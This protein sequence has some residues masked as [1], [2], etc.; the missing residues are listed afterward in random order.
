VENLRLRLEEL[1]SG[2]SVAESKDISHLLSRISEEKK[3]ILQDVFESVDV[4]CTTCVGSQRELLEGVH[5]PVVIVDGTKTAQHNTH[6]H[7]YIYMRSSSRDLLSHLVLI[8]RIDTSN[9][10]CGVVPTREILGTCNF[11]GR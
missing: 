7:T 6:T 9:G 1:Q 8:L 2:S 10:T 11:V 3:A 5:F 4:I